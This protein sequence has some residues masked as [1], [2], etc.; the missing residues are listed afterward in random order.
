MS[1]QP[2]A[3]DPNQPASPDPDPYA[4]PPPPPPPPPAGPPAAEPPPGGYTAPPPPV[5]GYGTPPPA[6]P[7]G[8]GPEPS[9]YGLPP[10]GQYPPPGQYPAQYPPAPGYGGMAPAGY[11]AEPPYAPW[12]SRVV[13]AL[14]D[15]FAPLLVAGVFYAISRPLGALLYVAALAWVIYN[16]VLEGQ[17]GQTYGK[18]AANIK[19]VGATTGQPIGAGLAILRYFLHI[20]DA[21][22]CYVGYLWPL[23]DSKRQTFA[24]KILSTYVVKV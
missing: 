20:V 23:W 14:I 8:G 4:A 9:N 16:K 12:G 7:Y 24:D 17:N 10:Q 19:L 13:A 15:Y 22:P 18:K 2:G 6:A 11:G 21:L 5:P 1:D 3:Q